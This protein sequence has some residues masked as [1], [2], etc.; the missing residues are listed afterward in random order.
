MGLDGGGAWNR[1]Q[2]GGRPAYAMKGP[3]WSD[4]GA[5]T[6]GQ[7]W[8]VLLIGGPSGV[9]KSVVAR[10]IGLRLGIPWLQVDDLRLALERSEVTLP[11]GTEALTSS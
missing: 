9:G 3:Q 1:P 11:S 5:I 7:E 2:W 4:G 6:P 8:R 10:S